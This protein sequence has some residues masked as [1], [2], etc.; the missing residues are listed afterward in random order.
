[1]TDA[2]RAPLEL[3]GGLECSIVRVG[4]EYRDQFLDIGHYDRPEDL[5][6]I[7][8]LGIRTIRYPVLWEKVSPTNP[9]TADFRWHDERLKRLSQL[10]MEPIVGLVH[11]GSGPRYTDLLDPAFPE[12]L[13]RHAARVAER[14]PHLRQFTPINEPLTTARFSALYGFWYPHKADTA[15]FFRALVNQCRATRLAM[16]AIRAVIPDARLV[17]TEDMGKIFSTPLLKYQADY[18]NER[19][20]LSLDLLFGRVVEGHPLYRHFLDNGIAQW[21]LEELSASPVPPDVVGIN[22]YLTSERFLEHRAH[23]Q[24][25]GHALGGNGRHRYADLEAVRVHLP[26]EE[27]GIEARLREVWQ[28]Y[29]TTI[30]VTEAHLGCTRDEQLR[31]LADI[32]QAASRV[33]AEGVDLCAVT[34]WSMFGSADWNSLMQR[35]AGHYEPGAFAIG[36]E[37]V[38]AT[39]LALAAQSISRHGGFDHPVLDGTGWWRRDDR[40]HKP[41]TLR[42]R[43][44]STRER[45]L[46][47][48]APPAETLAALQGVLRMRGLAAASIAPLQPMAVQGLVD[49]H[50]LTRRGIWAIILLST[51]DGDPL[52]ET[53]K[54]IARQHER[55]LLVFGFP[56]RADTANGASYRASCT[57]YPCPPNDREADAGGP[58]EIMLPQCEETLHPHGQTGFLHAGL[59]LLLDRG[60]PAFRPAPDVC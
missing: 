49:G 1:M 47:V 9:D 53:V 7:A 16:K 14:Y 8:A 4:D 32:W 28:R 25:H 15:S 13:A 22:Y 46:L 41:R 5:D 20:W 58:G 43:S 50:M 56:A 30:A 51:P 44:S 54:R 12:L 52:V 11:H 48:C 42:A 36:G 26:P 33:R 34:M 38:R 31:W 23:R 37:G 57:L 45:R 55:P 60:F 40:Y 10:G 59:D 18:E 27:T 17:Q 19:R 24:P 21:E 39:A 29:R 35:R 2:V 3:W 6:A